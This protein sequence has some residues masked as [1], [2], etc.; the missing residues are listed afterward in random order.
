MD[1]LQKGSLLLRPEKVL[2]QSS[3]EVR[4][5]GHLANL[6]TQVDNIEA[7]SAHRLAQAGLPVRFLGADEVLPAALVVV[8]LETPVA[9]AALTEEEA[10]EEATG[11][12]KEQR[13]EQYIDSV[14]LI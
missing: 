12:P 2:P 4:A 5:T 14:S 13:R 1:L 3:T 6:A 11:K 7:S 9:V 8:I 10:M